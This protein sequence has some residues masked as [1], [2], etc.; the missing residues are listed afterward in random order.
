MLQALFYPKSSFSE[1]V[2]EEYKDPGSSTY[3]WGLTVLNPDS[4]GTRILRRAAPDNPN[5]LPRLKLLSRY[6]PHTNSPNYNI[7]HLLPLSLGLWHLLASGTSAD[8]CSDRVVASFWLGMGQLVARLNNMTKLQAP[9]PLYSQ[10]LPF[11]F[12][13]SRSRV[14][15]AK[16][17][18]TDC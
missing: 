2:H 6:M 11:R 13:I 10:Q 9:I 17:E 3:Q 18:K 5:K 14:A 1:H 15:L 4:C 12:C 16:T 8:V 7:L